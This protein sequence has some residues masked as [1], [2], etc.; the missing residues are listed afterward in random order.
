[1]F[2]MIIRQKYENV[3]RTKSKLFSSAKI[4]FVKKISEFHNKFCGLIIGEQSNTT[5]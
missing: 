1:M 4:S 3:V 2:T 5:K